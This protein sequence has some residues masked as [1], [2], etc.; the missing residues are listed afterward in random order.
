MDINLVIP[1]Y[2]EVYS[3]N[4]IPAPKQLGNIF[5]KLVKSEKLSSPG[6]IMWGKTDSKTYRC[7]FHTFTFTFFQALEHIRCWKFDKSISHS[8]IIQYRKTKPKSNYR[9][10]SYDVPRWTEWLIKKGEEQQK[11]Q[12]HAHIHSSGY[13]QNWQRGR[14]GYS[15]TLLARSKK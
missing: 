11:V 9:A 3:S 13:R 15:Q 14:K 1:S 5:F 7:S 2:K 10:M 4:M 6:K 8:E 12:K